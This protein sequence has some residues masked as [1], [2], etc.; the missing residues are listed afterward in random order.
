MVRFT[1]ETVPEDKNLFNRDESF[2]E[3]VI[4]YWI[5]EADSWDGNNDQP[6]YN[7]MFETE[8][9]PNLKIKL[10]YEKWEEHGGELQPK[11]KSTF[12]EFLV[13]FLKLG[14][15]VEM[16]VPTKEVK[17]C[18]EIRG[19]R[20]AFVVDHRSFTSKN[21]EDVEVGEDGKLRPKVI[22]F[23]AWTVAAVG[24]GQAT[25]P[26]AEPSKPAPPKAESETPVDE[27]EIKIGYLNILKAFEYEAFTLPNIIGATSKYFK[28][29]PDVPNRS[30]YTAAVKRVKYLNSLIE[31][32]WITKG[33]DGKYKFV[34]G[35]VEAIEG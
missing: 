30:E 4:D 28:E 31:E 33:E 14:V 34:E 19:K 24:D 32:G 7:L 11:A 10:G 23:D 9:E 3:N 35:M 6:M 20:V 21:P 29:N 5:E 22:T 16:D 18:P 17:F 27:E 8:T 13:S 25:I 12:Y 26:T 15:E 2:S 1:L